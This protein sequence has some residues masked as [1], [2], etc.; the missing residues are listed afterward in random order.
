ME[1]EGERG[2]EMEREG[3]RGREMERESN[4][5]LL[6]TILNTKY[7]S[8]QN[9]FCKYNHIE[10]V[11]TCI[12]YSM[13]QCLFVWA[14][15]GWVTS[16]F[17]SFYFLKASVIRTCTCISMYII[18][19]T[20]SMRAAYLRACLRS[21]KPSTLVCSQSTRSDPATRRRF[22]DKINWQY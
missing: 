2:R 15:V 8:E 7:F 21:R 14:M 11:N 4:N 12:V 3:E 16:P 19:E 9:N 20:L 18:I 6:I 1:R 13:V 22:F 5:I 10:T 17:F